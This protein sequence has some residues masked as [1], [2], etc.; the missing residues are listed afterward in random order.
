MLGIVFELVL[1][2]IQFSSTILVPSSTAGSEAEIF[3]AEWTDPMFYMSFLNLGFGVISDIIT[4]LDD[5]RVFFMTVCVILPL[6]MTFFGLFYLN[7]S[8]VVLWY[9]FTLAFFLSLCIGALAKILGSAAVINM[10]DAVAEILLFAGLGGSVLCWIVFLL[11]FK[12][13]FGRLT[14]EGDEKVNRRRQMAKDTKDM[15]VRGTA[16]LAAMALVW[17]VVG[18]LFVNVI[19][20][21]AEDVDSRVT[22]HFALGLGVVFLVFSAIN[23]IFLILSLFQKGREWSWKF[24]EFMKHTFLKILLLSLSLLY[25]P[26]GASTFTVFNCN[27]VECPPGYRIPDQGMSIIPNSTHGKCIP[28]NM[29]YG[30]MCPM[31]IRSS[32]CEGMV[33]DRME[34][35][36][37]IGCE[38]MRSF[39][40]PA[41]VLVI[42][43]YVLGVPLLFFSEIRTST[44]LLMDDFPIKEPAVEEGEDAADF[45]QRRW[46]LKVLMCD[47][48]ARFLFEAF[49]FKFR[50]MRLMQLIQKLIVVFTS[51]FV[52]RYGSL[53]PRFIVLGTSL[54]VH[55]LVTVVFVAFRPFL[56]D[57]H[58]WVAT[59]LQGG[60]CL[61]VIVALV[62]AAEVYVP[63][64][65]L[66]ITM[67]FNYALPGLAAVFSVVYFCYSLHKEAEEEEA[68]MKRRAEAEAGSGLQD[69]IELETAY[70]EKPPE[71]TS[72]QKYIMDVGAPSRPPARSKSIVARKNAREQQRRIKIR[73]KVKQEIQ[74]EMDALKEQQMDSDVHIDQRMQK[75]LRVFLMITGVL[76]TIALGLCVLGLWSSKHPD[77]R[78][79]FGTEMVTGN[80]IAGF[81]SWGNF[82]SSCCCASSESS[83]DWGGGRAGPLDVELWM[84]RGGVIQERIRS[85]AY[86]NVT[87]GS[88]Y[89]ADGFHVRPLC[90]ASFINN[91]SLEVSEGSTLSLM[92]PQGDQNETILW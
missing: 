2:Y 76:A 54:A 41:G 13:C 66:T 30:Q 51:V 44:R 34:T 37:Y 25:I 63:S 21:F 55:F 50:Y 86:R 68:E 75:Q 64:A 28:C 70:P 26:I 10:P 33:D 79:S 91:C 52:I 8:K 53:S 32:M 46:E 74:T 89:R 5:L 90:G 81:Q 47:N 15:D 58:D 45:E 16:M 73:E 92:C 9:F 31:D 1:S 69:D 27:T 3:P 4:S 19:P 22:A 72:A 59:A 6:A 82:T 38:G 87:D 14:A 56:L 48:S 71:S 84:C 43:F 60:L 17:L 12:G 20:A 83:F 78:T 29:N 11:A 40:W 65:V 23:V 36:L 39:F 42:L 57:L 77:V 85:Y 35:A 80:Q 49:E 24:Q 67:V 62:V 18:L 61:V 88:L 7:T